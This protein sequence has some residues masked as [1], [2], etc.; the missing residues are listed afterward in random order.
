MIEATA[1]DHVCLAVSS[2]GRSRDYYERVLGASCKLR[3]NDPATLVVEAAQV[4]F[5]LSES[6]ANPEFL[7]SQHLS[8]RVRS[9][10]DVISALNALGITE[11]ETGAIN[12]FE[13]DNYRWCEWRDPDGIRL[14]CVE[15]LNE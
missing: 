8:L 12:L 11:Y 7:S 13:R 10:E 6:L 1:I 3:D 5:F 4:R 9:L 15:L 2:L 14:E